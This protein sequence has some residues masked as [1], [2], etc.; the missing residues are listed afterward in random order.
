[1]K[2][3]YQNWIDNYL[4]KHKFCNG[5]CFS[6]TSAMLKCFPELIQVKGY[7]FNI[8]DKK[9]NHW[10]LKTIDNE[11]IDP[12]VSQFIIIGDASFIKYEEYCELKYGPLPTGKCMDCGKNI[13][14]NGAFCNDICATNTVKYLNSNRMEI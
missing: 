9:Y 4:L 3:E 14:H 10:W 8:H 6:A 12:T 13:Y 1:M 5:L 7:I 2:Q 11:I